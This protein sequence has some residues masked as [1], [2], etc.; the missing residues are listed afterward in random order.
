VSRFTIRSGR[1]LG[2]SLYLQSIVRHLVE[3][4]RHPSVI[5]D[6]PAVFA[7]LGVPVS[8][9]RRKTVDVVAHYVARKEVPG[10]TIFEDMCIAAGLPR[11]IPLR[12]D[13]P[14]VDRGF[15]ADVRLAARDLPIVLVQQA[16]EPFG[17]SDG[18]GI[19]LLPRF[20]AMQRA[21]DRL[22]DHAFLVQVGA[23]PS[24]HEFRNIDLNLIDRTSLPQLLDLAAEASGFL[25]YCSFFVPLAE[26]LSKPSLLIWSTR[27]LRS[28]VP[29]IRSITPAKIL[30][31]PDLSRWVLDECPESELAGAV[32]AFRDAVGSSAL[33]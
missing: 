24:I 6:W 12:L 25:G 13:R 3:E 1:G 17:R 11:D 23:G 15:V 19:D 20:G 7:H 27:G 5:S 33:V 30:H 10:T 32:H 22:K 26:S 16:R 14:V 28:P 18:Y 9:F 21:I 29:Y 4:G 2:D 31:R 8:P